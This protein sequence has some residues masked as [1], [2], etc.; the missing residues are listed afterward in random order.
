MTQT[1]IPTPAPMSHL[2]SS[3]APDPART[4]RTL[5]HQFLSAIDVLDALGEYVAAAHLATTIDTLEQRIATIDGGPTI[6]D[7]MTLADVPAGRL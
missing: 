4:L 3:P 7:E 2:D 6:A 1:Y 5:H